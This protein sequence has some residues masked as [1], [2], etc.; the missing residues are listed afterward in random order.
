M[1]ILY[2]SSL[3]YYVIFTK[4]MNNNGEDDDDRQEKLLIFYEIFI[5]LWAL[6][7]DW[8][9]IASFVICKVVQGYFMKNIFCYFN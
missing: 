6:K 2:I 7:E 4:Q 5:Q 3:F 9:F 8:I 1:E